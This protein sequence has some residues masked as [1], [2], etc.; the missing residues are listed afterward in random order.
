MLTNQCEN[1]IIY[2]INHVYVVKFIKIASNS[3]QTV[4][5]E[6]KENTGNTGRR[7]SA[8]PKEQM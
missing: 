8:S 1:K 6:Q 4:N 2:I 3:E 5:T 7:N